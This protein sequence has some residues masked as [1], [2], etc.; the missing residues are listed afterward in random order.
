MNKKLI[1]AVIIAATVSTVADAA[2][3]VGNCITDSMVVQRNSHLKIS[4][5]ASGTVRAKASWDEGR[6]YSVT[7]GR[8][9]AF[10]IIMP[11]P[12]AGGPYSISIS[13]SDGSI[14]KLQ[15][16][17]SGEVWLCSGQSNMEMP[18]AGWGLVNN[19]EAE[20]ADAAN[21][22]R[23]RLLQINRHIATT[24]QDE[25]IVNMGGWRKAAP[26][27][28][29]NFSS[30]AYFFA[31]ELSDSLGGIPVGVIDCSWGGTPAE[32]WTPMES[33]KAIGDLDCNAVDY[34]AIHGGKMY[35]DYSN[36]L[37]AWENLERKACDLDVS[38]AYRGWQKMYLPMY[39]EKSVLPDF[40][41]VVW[42]QR[43]VI[44]PKEMQNKALTLFL[45]RI[46]DGDLTFVNGTKV[47]ETW[48]YDQL[49]RYEIPA[50]LAGEKLLISIRV[51]DNSGGGGIWGFPEEMNVTDGIT[52]INLS[53]EWNFK[54]AFD[55][56]KNPRPQ[57]PYYFRS[58]SVL[59]NAMVYPLRDL[60]LAGVIWYQ[61]C[62]NVGRAGQYS[63]LFP[64]MIEDW[65][66]LFGKEKMPFYFVQ[67][68][69]FQ[70]PHLVQPDSE[71]AALRQA[72]TS[73]LKLHQTGM[74]TAIDI[75]EAD[76]I[77]PK[78]KQEVARRLSLLAL[79][80][81]YGQN[82]S[83]TAPCPSAISF[84]G[85]KA[86]IRFDDIVVPVAAKPKGIIV[87]IEDGSW[88]RPRI[89]MA[90]DNCLMLESPHEI[91]EIRYNWADNPDGNLY[92]KS[93]LPVLPFQ[94]AK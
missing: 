19:Y 72:Q 78:N 59:Y 45:G 38:K 4:G 91:F 56:G 76:D 5:K 20:I 35:A 34:D 80:N 64:C 81:T 25:A 90:A 13:D 18:L 33:C 17:Y 61:G 92:G 46:D 94:K 23:I 50:E 62:D 54:A 26:G 88:I 93:G 21:Y 1:V 24:P 67:L 15:D 86:E 44:L 10:S 83:A 11:T 16:I 31:R 9:S 40:D 84:R 7:A 36:R 47:G 74:A 73:A 29:D 2:I 53:G 89:V 63:R 79:K 14:K 65:R 52:T 22:P 57:P 85:K 77:H 60:D 75:G 8:D 69:G 37:S 68:A 41:G 71:W 66:K 27:A 82:V 48:I 28:V 87:R 58:P 55:F 42:F 12:E 32:A 39:W 70:Q 49:R 30:V 43:E 3:T 51:T 6:E